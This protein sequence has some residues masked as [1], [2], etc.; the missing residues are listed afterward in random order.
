LQ[1]FSKG[2]ESITSHLF[3]KCKTAGRV[4]CWGGTGSQ[5]VRIRDIVKITA[6]EDKRSEV[7]A[8]A[9]TISTMVK[10]AMLKMAST[11]DTVPSDISV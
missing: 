1:H 4:R 10:V 3:G 9:V 5:F 6:I 11:D 8:F 7:A 2:Q